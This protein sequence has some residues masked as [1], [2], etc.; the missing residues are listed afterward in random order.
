MS[1]SYL[2][3]E[4]YAEEVFRRKKA[5]ETNRQICESVSNR[6]WA[7]DITYMSTKNALCCDHLCGAA[8]WC[9][10]GESELGR[11]I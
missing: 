11:V 7:T 6:L 8:R 3:V 2:K 5:G 4:P 10:H 1:R 9:C